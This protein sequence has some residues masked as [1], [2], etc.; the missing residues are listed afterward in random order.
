L[1]TL[2]KPARRTAGQVLQEGGQSLVEEFAPV[3]RKV[4]E[5]AR[6]TG[7]EALRQAE[8]MPG[9][10]PGVVQ[11][12]PGPI[13]P[14][15]GEGFKLPSQFARARVSPWYGGEQSNILFESD[16]DR[17]LFFAT[18]K[19]PPKDEAARINRETIKG[20]VREE[21]QARGLD[22]KKWMKLLPP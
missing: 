5:A 12:A 16:F 7:R 20:L 15:R 19:G 6:A 9:G 18:A 13:I 22:P 10:I 17:A 14:G 2:E 11:A 21:L 1:G 4:E 3:T 8:R